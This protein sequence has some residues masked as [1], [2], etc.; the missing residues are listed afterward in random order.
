MKRIDFLKTCGMAC[1]GSSTIVTLFQSCVTGANY[2]A[3]SELDGQYLK[4]LKTEFIS[5]K[6]VN[7]EYVIVKAEQLNFPIYLHKINESE[8]SA[9]WMECSHQS[10][11]LSAHGEYLTCPSHGSEFDKL[12]NV[13]QGPAQQ[14]LR[15]FKTSLDNQY[16]LIQL[17]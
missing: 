8:Y 17:S 2:Y 13:T 4:V 9:V 1:L 3:K 7:R 10:A 16:I 5:A 11:E 6:N 15:K 14:S 12:G